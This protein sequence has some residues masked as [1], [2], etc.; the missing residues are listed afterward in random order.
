MEKYVVLENTW[1]VLSPS[2]V[3]NK[4]FK[5]LLP[6]SIPSRATIDPPTNRHL[7]MAVRWRAESGPIVR[8]DWIFL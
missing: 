3:L 8:A 1:D 4:I 6:A 5:Q 2:A 7:R